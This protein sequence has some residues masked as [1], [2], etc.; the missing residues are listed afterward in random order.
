MLLLIHLDAERAGSGTLLADGLFTFGR[1]IAAGVGRRPHLGSILQSPAYANANRVFS[2][3][4]IP[5]FMR[6]TLPLTPH[7]SA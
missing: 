3:D 7:G 5:G 1:F 4:V 2:Q 6:K